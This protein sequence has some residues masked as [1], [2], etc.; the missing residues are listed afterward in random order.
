MDGMR[1]FGITT[2]LGTVLLIVVLQGKTQTR[3]ARDIEHI[4]SNQGA[5]ASAF[6][7]YYDEWRTHEDIPSE[8]DML[9]AAELT[10][11]NGELARQK[12]RHMDV[13]I[14]LTIGSLWP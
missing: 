3:I 8:F 11:V 12:Q 14:N 1:Y 10:K 4:Q 5:Y 2:L 9:L 7:A 6:N 13:A